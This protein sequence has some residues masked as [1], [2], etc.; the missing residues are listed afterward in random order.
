MGDKIKRN[1]K[2]KLLLQSDDWKKK[3][4]VILN[5][6]GFKCTTCN[7]K[8]NLQVHH[9]IYIQGKNPWEYKDH[10]LITLCKDCHEKH[11]GVFKTKTIKNKSKE[12]KKS[13]FEKMLRKL[14]P[15]DRAIQKKY[16][17]IKAMY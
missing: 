4:M 7:C 2:Y 1:E 8:R 16:D 14:S 13:K 9:K 10:C 11:H 17:S 12:N 5:R 6:D 3:R 15:K